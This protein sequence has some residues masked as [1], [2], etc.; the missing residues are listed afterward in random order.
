MVETHLFLLDASLSPSPEGLVRK[1]S[2]FVALIVT[3]L[4]CVLDLPQRFH[5]RNL[6]DRPP[7]G[8]NEFEIIAL[9][10][11]LKPFEG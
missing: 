1:I 5:L 4:S 9:L 2:T 7:K 3:V 8:Y 10:K 11:S 6:N